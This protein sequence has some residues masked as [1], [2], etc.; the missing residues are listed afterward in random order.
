[1]NIAE[2]EDVMST[3]AMW[4][5]AGEQVAVATDPFLAA[6]CYITGTALDVAGGLPNFRSEILLQDFSKK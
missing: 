1:M 6:E 4:R 5:A 2:T 3:A